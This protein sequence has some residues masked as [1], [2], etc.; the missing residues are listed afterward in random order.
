MEALTIYGI[1]T[2][3]FESEEAAW[4]VVRK[5]ILQRSRSAAEVDSRASRS[6]LVGEFVHNTSPA[7]LCGCLRRIL[8]EDVSTLE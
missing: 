2:L 5:F 1:S 3:G 4:A 6:Y 8:Q 7:T